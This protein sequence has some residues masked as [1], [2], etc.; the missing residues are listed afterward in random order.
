MFPLLFYSTSLTL[1]KKLIENFPIKKLKVDFFDKVIWVVHSMVW[2]M[3]GTKAFVE[4]IYLPVVTSGNFRMETQQEFFST[5]CL[6]I[7]IYFI[8]CYYLLIH[9]FTSC[10]LTAWLKSGYVRGLLKK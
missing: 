7:Y 8:I 4:I 9:L 6:F 5:A 1:K 10:L 2:A 3:I